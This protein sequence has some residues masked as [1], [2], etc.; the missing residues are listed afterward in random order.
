MFNSNISPKK[1]TILIGISAALYGLLA[2]FGTQLL[3]ANFSIENM[4]FWRFFIAGLWMVGFSYFSKKKTSQD[5]SQVWKTILVIFIL[6]AL[7]Y[8][9]S[10]GFYFAATKYISTGLAMVIF[11]SYP[12]L[13]ALLV[14]VLDKVTLSKIVIFSLFFMLAGLWLLKGKTGGYHNLLGLGYALLAAASYAAYVF[15]T[16]WRTAKLPSELSTIIVCLGCA[17]TFL[18]LT[19]YTHTFK[20]PNTWHDW[21]YIFALSILATAIPIQLMLEGLKQ[22]SALEASL[23]SSLEPLVTVAVG[24]ILLGETIT[25]LQALGCLFILISSL[26]MQL[27]GVKFPK[28][29]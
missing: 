22:V 24:M 29:R 11:F 16:R 9:G 27:Q 12:V 7:G 2:F 4:L 5:Y 18:L 28:I 6:G 14:F 10:C 19:L 15:G 26:V 25:S 17:F 20:L 23:L 21:R 1:A 3:R 13:V 8:S